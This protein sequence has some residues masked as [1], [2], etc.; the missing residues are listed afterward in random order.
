MITTSLL[1][2]LIAFEIWYLTS[3]QNKQNNTSDYVKKLNAQSKL[4]RQS[5]IVLVILSAI[6]LCLKLGLTSGLTATLF[7]LMAV[8]SLV[9]TV[10]P[11]RYIRYSTLAVL[12]V[13]FLLLE[14]FI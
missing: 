3:K 4:F 12:Y 5:T 7:C 2:L 10:Q 1:L 9:V 14:I 13:V 11:F 6:L 8:G